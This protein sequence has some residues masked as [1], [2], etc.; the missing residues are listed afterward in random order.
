M[1]GYINGHPF[2]GY[3]QSRRVR[4]AVVKDLRY[5]LSEKVTGPP[6]QSPIPGKYIVAFKLNGSLYVIRNG[7]YATVITD[8]SSWLAKKRFERVPFPKD[9][10]LVLSKHWIDD[11]PDYR[12]ERQFCEDL[13][14]QPVSQYCISL[15]KYN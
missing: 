10:V 12:S 13:A 2:W 4:D 14:E 6:R 1:Q 7:Y 15:G 11:L 3:Y 8:D 9:G 5:A